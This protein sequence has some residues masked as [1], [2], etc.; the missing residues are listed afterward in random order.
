MHLNQLLLNLFN[1]ILIYYIK[2]IKKL[3]AKLKIYT[4]LLNKN[5]QITIIIKKKIVLKINIELSAFSTKSLFK[6]IKFGI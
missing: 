1:L 6:V 2:I 3:P 5:P 4:R